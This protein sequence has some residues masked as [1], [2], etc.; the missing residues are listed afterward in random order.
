MVLSRVVV[1]HLWCNISGG[2]RIFTVLGIYCLRTI[3]IIIESKANH[4]AI[5]HGRSFYEK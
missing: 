4:V 5:L 2:K 3:D 1:S